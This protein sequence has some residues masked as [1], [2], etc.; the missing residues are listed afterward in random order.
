M[1]KKIAIF[2]GSRA[3]YG[4][5]YWLMAGIKKNKLFD[6]QLIVS[7]MHLSP[8]HGETWREIEC[9]GFEISAKVEMLLSSD[10]PVGTTKSIGLGVIGFADALDRL[11]PDLIIVLGDRYEALAITQAA[12]I[13]RIP[14]AHIHG[15]ETTEGA[16]DDSIRH[17][18]TKLSTF[19]F[20]STEEYRRR[21]IQMGENPSKVVNIGAIG[22]DHLRRTELLSLEELSV[23]LNFEIR[24]PYFVV[25]YH[26]ATI[27]AEDPGTTFKNI[28]KALDLFP[29]HQ[30]IL[31]FPNSDDGA[32]VITQLIESYVKDHPTRAIAVK[33]LGSKRYLSALKWAAAVIGN[34]SS[35][36]IEA[37]SFSIPSINVGTRQLGRLSAESVIHAKT[38]D[39]SI[40]RAIQFALDLRCSKDAT[41]VFSNPYGGGNASEVIIDFI[42]KMNKPSVQKT[43]YDWS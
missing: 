5:L 24:Q 11:K 31:T 38:D 16:Y 2:T 17:A 30:V 6:L 25:T 12:L 42:E 8:S 40:V 26:P 37:P 18:I 1:K 35:G 21:V 10:T 29:S 23:N 20:T 39:G 34:S 36:I 3:E 19:H 32:Y 28:L 14:I 43:F 15:G 13:F 33:S 9:D 7:G 22:L 27:G 41:D 4:L